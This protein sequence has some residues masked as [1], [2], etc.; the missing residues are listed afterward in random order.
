MS[1][2]CWFVGFCRIQGENPR[3][4][5]TGYCRSIASQNAKRSTAQIFHELERLEQELAE[6]DVAR[7]YGIVPSTADTDTAFRTLEKRIVHLENELRKR[8]RT[9]T[10]DTV[11]H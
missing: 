9:D 1:P 10:P 2:T 6:L 7:V 11:I 4:N 5:G 3:G 8:F